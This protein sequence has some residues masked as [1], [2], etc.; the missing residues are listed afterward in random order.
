MNKYVKI[1]KKK[2]NKN[3]VWVYTSQDLA[4]NSGKFCAVIQPHDSDI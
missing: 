1:V 2:N 4:T 3:Q